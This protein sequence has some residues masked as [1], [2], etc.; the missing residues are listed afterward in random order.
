MVGGIGTKVP[1]A[2][3]N[4]G[5]RTVGWLSTVGWLGNLHYD[6]KICMMIKG[7]RQ[8]GEALGGG[9]GSIRTKPKVG[10]YDM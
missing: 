4:G 8:T 7:R 9:G 3:L 5:A 6:R 2:K 10:A 1:T